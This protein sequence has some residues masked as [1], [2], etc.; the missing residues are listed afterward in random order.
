MV[1]DAVGS[2]MT[3]LIDPIVLAIAY[4]TAFAPVTPSFGPT[5]YCTSE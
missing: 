2:Y 5:A 3:V 4:V 1:W